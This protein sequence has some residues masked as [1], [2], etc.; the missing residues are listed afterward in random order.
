MA[1]SLQLMASL[2]AKHHNDNA[3]SKCMRNT[4]E[5]LQ[6]D[7]KRLA[8]REAR[9]LTKSLSKASAQFR[10]AIAELKRQ[11]AKAHA[12]IGRLQRQV[13]KGFGAPVAEVDTEKVRYSAR[14]VTAQR[15]RLGI[16][17]AEFGKLIGVTAHTIYAWEHA[18]S[19]PRKAQLAAFAAL[20]G[21]G[22][23]E[24][25]VR[26]EQLSVKSVKW[27][28]KKRVDGGLE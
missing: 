5:M 9:S 3:R 22:K 1:P 15:K 8:R 13:L 16:S 2:E 14:S 25:K 7:I 10:R 20:R 28:K 17:A 4:A 18:T 23:T 26:L 21:L 12:E 11:V 19:K 24:A 27:R 6:Q